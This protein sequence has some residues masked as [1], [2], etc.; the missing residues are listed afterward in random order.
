MTNFVTPK[1]VAV[2]PKLNQPDYKFNVDGEYSVKLKLSAEESQGL[3]KQ[4]EDERDAYK[5]E[6][7]KKNPKVSNYNL[8]SV[9]EEEIDDQGNLTGFN[10]FKFKQKA[11]IKT[12]SGDSIKKTVALYDSNKTPTDV[13]VN[14]GSTIKVAA[15]TFCYD[16]PSSKMV[17]ISL[18]P[19]AVQIIEL[20]QGAGG[21]EALAMFDKED[22][23]VADTFNNVEAVAVSDDADF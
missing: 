9:Y 12:K 19:T 22:G 2:W 6:V 17:G 13:V 21:V 5:A 23:F 18:R 1:G 20:S 10:L 3:I 7:T 11:V 8:A 14:G 16:M 15:S 4:L